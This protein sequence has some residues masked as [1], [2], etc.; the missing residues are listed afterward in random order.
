VLERNC[1]NE[2]IPIGTPEWVYALSVVAQTKADA[3]ALGQNKATSFTDVKTSTTLS[4][5]E[6]G[7]ILSSAYAS[8][9]RWLKDPALRWYIECLGQDPKKTI[10]TFEAL[11]RGHIHDN[12]RNKKLFFSGLKRKACV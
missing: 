6:R 4:H 8:M 12:H 5:S 2:P 3:K 11:C 1:W 7:E 10:A 9:R